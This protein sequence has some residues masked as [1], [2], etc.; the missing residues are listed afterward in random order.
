MTRSLIIA[1]AQT[2]PIQRAD[3]RTHTLD[4]LIALLEQAAA[5]GAQM[6]VF[7]ELA[8]TT[9]FPRWL[10]ETT[11]ELDTWY[12][13]AMPN[14]NCQR[15]FDR[16]RELGVGFYLGYAF[17]LFARPQDCLSHVLVSTPF[18]SHPEF[19]YP[20]QS[21]RRL[22]TRDGSHIDTADAVV[23]LAEIPVVRLRHGLPIALQQGA[24]SFNEAV[25]AIQASLGPPLLEID[26]TAG[27]VSC[28]GRLV[29]MKPQ[30][31]AWLAWWAW[32]RKEQ[33]GDG[34]GFVGWRSASQ[35]D[36]QAF[37]AIYKALVGLHSG[38][39]ESTAKLLASD[40]DKEFFQ[41]KNS[42]LERALRD[43][44]GAAATAYSLAQSG[45]RPHTRRGLTL[46]SNAIRITG[47]PRNLP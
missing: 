28:G 11:Q 31:V 35:A 25:A 6:V 47:L 29:A 43:T 9:F 40:M 22:A 4:R 5:Q 27:R 16:A 45:T 34:E 38:D 17:S 12:E 30:L 39:F 32:L 14:P 13:R 46:P 23:T 2:G 8:L 10:M 44:L 1:G 36:T 21:P 33:R 7:P 3:N 42:K 20:P 19:F 26:L 37:L 15:L 24:A 18:E 41:Q